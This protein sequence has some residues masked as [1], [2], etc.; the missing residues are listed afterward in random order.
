MTTEEDLLARC[1]YLIRTYKQDATLI[2]EHRQARDAGLSPLVKKRR[3]FEVRSGQFV[4]FAEMP[5]ADAR[6]LLAANAP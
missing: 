2:L 5:A 6:K 3:T 1:D 4:T